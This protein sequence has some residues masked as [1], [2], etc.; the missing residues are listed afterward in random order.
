MGRA[1]AAA[2]DKEIVA[3]MSS[4]PMWNL[5]TVKKGYYTL[6][7]GR[8]KNYYHFSKVRFIKTSPYTRRHQSRAVG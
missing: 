7:A 8:G 1:A 6:H 4:R 3:S 5:K 2:G